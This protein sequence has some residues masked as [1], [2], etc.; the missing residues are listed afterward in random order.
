MIL[1]TPKNQQKISYQKKIII[2]INHKIKIF[3][4]TLE[5]RQ[6]IQ[7]NRLCKLINRIFLRIYFNTENSIAET[8]VTKSCKVSRLIRTIFLKIWRSDIDS[9][10]PSLFLKVEVTRI[11]AIGFLNGQNCQ[12]EREERFQNFE[13]F[14]SVL[15]IV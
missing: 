2:I 10:L 14:Y 1:K 4:M 11:L 15:L 6:M 12:T 13:G 9:R 5:G 8:K 7:E 3:I